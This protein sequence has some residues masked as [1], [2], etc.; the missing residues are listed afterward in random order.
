MASYTFSKGSSPLLISMPH[1]GQDIPS[2]IANV[3]T[4]EALLLKDTDWFID[5]LYDFSHEMGATVIKPMMSRYVIDLNRGVDGVNLYP[6][7]DSTELCP[8]STFNRAPIY[9]NKQSVTTTEV[10]RRVTSYWEPYHEKIKETLAEIKAEFG[11]AII[12]DAH[13]ILSEVPRFFDGKLPDFNWGTVNQT[14]CSKEMLNKL[15][16]INYKSYSV[17][18]NA[19]FKGGYITR[20]YGDPENNIH[21]I[22]L[23]LSQHTYMNENEFTFNTILADQVKP[24]LQTIVETLIDH[25]PNIVNKG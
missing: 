1:T 14:S 22:Q 19:R 13:S 3:M 15:M 4:A 16:R 24:V 21:A 12:L 2:R 25:N 5:K 10:N 6:G 9:L 8:S 11:F 20:Q 18:S 23:E 17:V 7:A